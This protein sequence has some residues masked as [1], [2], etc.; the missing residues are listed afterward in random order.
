MPDD[1]L[2]Y[3]HQVY[4][5]YLEFLET[6]NIIFDASDESPALTGVNL[7]REKIEKIYYKNAL[8]VY[9]QLKAKMKAL[10]YPVDGGV[11]PPQSPTVRITSPADEAVFTVGD[12]L[13]IAATASDSDGTVARVQ[14]FYDRNSSGTY[15][16]ISNDTV[17][18]YSAAWNNLPTGNHRIKAIAVDNTGRTS[19]SVIAISVGAG[20]PDPV[21]PTVRITSPADEVSLVTGNNLTI[22]ATASDADGTIE[23]VKFLKDVN[24]TGIYTVMTNDTTSPYTTAW[25][26]LPRGQHR[27]KAVATDND[28]KKS[29]SI[30]T[31]RVSATG[32]RP[33]ITDGETIEFDI[34][35]TGLDTSTVL[36]NPYRGTGDIVFANIPKATVIKIFTL[37]GKTV[38]VVS[39][40][41]AGN[42]IWN[43]TTSDGKK[44]APG[45]YYAR[46]MSGGET[47]TV[48]IVCNK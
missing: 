38:A 27:I 42:A 20:T 43:V 46:I 31:I 23:S 40:D 1:K 29:T 33:V 37:S 24:S 5:C 22:R 28:G 34:S 4:G 36:N 39:A 14:F 18:P 30:V 19:E 26:N 44:A 8:K 45:V 21:A 9:P 2:R 15:T 12:N 10:G 17:A 6:E 47:K 3:I 11:T 13:T 41:A 48:K 7:S 25:N 35:I 32:T 16:L